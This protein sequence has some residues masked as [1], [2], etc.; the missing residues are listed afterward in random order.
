VISGC[1]DNDYIEHLTVTYRT[2]T[3]LSLEPSEQTYS[4]HNEVAS[5]AAPST[6]SYELMLNIVVI[7]NIFLTEFNIYLKE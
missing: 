6:N 1:D 4:W 7:R 2:V 3:R 5:H